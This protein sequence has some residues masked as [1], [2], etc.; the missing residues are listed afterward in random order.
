[1]ARTKWGPA[2]RITAPGGTVVRPLGTLSCGPDTCGAGI[3]DSPWGAPDPRANGAQT[4]NVGR[5]PAAGTADLAH[6]GHFL[7]R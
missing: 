6:F 3:G 1:M 7:G 5:F 4:A 2:L